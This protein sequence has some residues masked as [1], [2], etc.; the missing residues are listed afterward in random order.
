MS[1]S[2]PRMRVP[3][4]AFV[5]LLASLAVAP[6]RADVRVPRVFSGNAVL[7]RQMPIP[8]WGWAD[9]QEEVA[10]EMNGRTARARADADGEWMVRLPAMEAGGPFTLTIAGKNRIEIQ[11]VLVGEVWV[12][13]GQSN[14][15]M[16]VAG[17]SYAQREI[18]EGDYPAIRMFAT[19]AR[20]SLKPLPDVP[21]DWGVCS[22]QNVGTFSA[23][24][25]F[26]GR[27][28]QQDLNVPVGL[29]NSSWGGTRIEPWTPRAALEGLETVKDQL[30]ALDRVV[31]DLA[32]PKE[33]HREKIAAAEK[34]AQLVKEMEADEALGAQMAALDLDDAAWKQMDLPQAWE[35]KELPDFNGLVWFRKAVDLP[36]DW[37]GKDLTMYLCPAD[38]VDVTWFNGTV[39]GRT[40]S[41]AAND[42]LKYWDVPRAYKVPGNLV[43][44]GRNVI[45]VRVIDTAF[46]GGLWSQGPV[47]MEL[48]WI[49]SDA[50]PVPLAGPWRYNV[51]AQLIPMP[52]QLDGANSPGL[53]TALYN[54]M[55]H[56]L[57]PFAM[58]GAIWYQGE[59]NLADGPLY[60]DKMAALITGWR[61]AWGGGDFPFYYVQLAPYHYGADANPLPRLW[62]A[63]LDALKIPN[64]GMA[65][66]VDVGEARDIHPRQKQEVGDRL[67]LW[68]LARTYGRK[69]VVCSGPLFKS[70]TVEGDKVRVSFD[71][72]GGGLVSLNDRPLVWFEVAGKD[73]GF[74][75]AQA[76]IDGDCVVVSS[77]QVMEPVA[78]R[79]AWDQDADPS[80]MNRE[81]LPASPFT[82]ARE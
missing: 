30:Q 1:L 11:N 71:H 64:T 66:T 79:Y 20:T 32:S 77:P 63:Q 14:M 39:V 47:R 29:I 74:V 45:A 23:V 42:V 72:V 18:A 41:F 65:V 28:L 57:V 50:K 61:Q 27:R 73:G 22:P 40:G 76:H 5:L 70:M 62:Q 80:L 36:A 78:V 2:A 51:G 7:Q 21:G 31:Q 82:T 81:G 58:R 15:A 44:A 38:E 75:R 3:I 9:P 67:A 49:A 26:F 25:Y 34:S 55:I 8:V 54:G 16:T 48:E 24:G 17:C 52:P 35:A 33:E 4:A 10:V 12:C 60:T 19:T 6:L 56:P 68:A 37:A 43:K 59:S 69:N 53:A 46:A 13:S